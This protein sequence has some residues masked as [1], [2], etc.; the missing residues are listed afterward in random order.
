M[1][2]SGGDVGDEKAVLPL[3]SLD[4]S[5]PGSNGQALFGQEAPPPPAYPWV[6]V[7][8]AVDHPLYARSQYGPGAGRG[9]PGMVAGLQGHVDGGSLANWTGLAQGVH[10]G[11]G[12]PGLGV[13]SLAHNPSIGHH[14]RAH[15]RVGRTKRP[16]PGGS[17]PG[18]AHEM[19]VLGFFGDG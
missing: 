9:A 17:G 12:L 7:R 3:T 8:G 5:T 18:P 6:G 19:K 16:T 15:R 4:P 10:L 1:R 13:P 11:V 14:H 2:P